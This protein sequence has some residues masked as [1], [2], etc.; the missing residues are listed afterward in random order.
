MVSD[1]G[2]LPASDRD[3]FSREGFCRRG[4]AGRTNPLVETR[5]DGPHVFYRRGGI[6]IPPGQNQIKMNGNKSIDKADISR[7][8]FIAVLKS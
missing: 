3:F 7:E 4:P 5:A 2:N 8:A 1:V 6:L